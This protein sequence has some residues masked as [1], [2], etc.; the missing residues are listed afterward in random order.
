MT[1]I[2]LQIIYF[3]KFII[4]HVKT[5]AIPCPHQPN[6]WLIFV[7]K[8]CVCVCVCVLTEFGIE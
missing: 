1:D 6:K 5:R 7:Y 8:S 2:H 3:K 4:Q